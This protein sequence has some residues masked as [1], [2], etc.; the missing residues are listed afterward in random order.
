MSMACIKWRSENAAKTSNHNQYCLYRPEL[1]IETQAAALGW[2]QEKVSGVRSLCASKFIWA[3]RWITDPCKVKFSVA[4]SK[5]RFRL[6][7]QLC[8][9]IGGCQYIIANML[10]LLFLQRLFQ[11][12]KFSQSGQYQAQSS[13]FNNT[14]LT[15]PLLL[16]LTLTVQETAIYCFHLE[17]LN[18]A[19]HGPTR[20][21]VFGSPPST[22]L[23]HIY[24]AKCGQRSGAPG[25]SLT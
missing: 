1:F 13:L 24:R 15:A 25:Q 6:S 23:A 2:R 4:L 8:A 21:S 3:K 14:L 12:T 5:D 7:Q 20:D 18:R 22:C 10:L 19:S 17:P 16:T 9:S 11:E